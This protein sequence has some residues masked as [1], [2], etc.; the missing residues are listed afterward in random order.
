[1]S[2][3]KNF[4]IIAVVFMPCFVE[5]IPFN[6]TEVPFE[7]KGSSLLSFRVVSQ[8]IRQTIK[9]PV[10]LVD[11][12]FSCIK[13]GYE[14]LSGLHSPF[15]S[16]T[17]P[18]ETM[19]SNDAEK[20]NTGSNKGANNCIIY[21]IILLPPLP[22]WYAILTEKDLLENYIVFCITLGAEDD[23]GA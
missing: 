9:I 2:K 15:F 20:S 13:G 10:I 12:F 4:C 3:I 14:V 17:P 7:L 23:N 16:T 5:A 6:K 11:S 18:G 22:L 8:D 1:V 21:F 19:I